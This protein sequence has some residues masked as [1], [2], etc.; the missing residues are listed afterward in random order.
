[1][2]DSENDASDEQKTECGAGQVKIITGI[3]DFKNRP[4]VRKVI[5]L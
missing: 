1:M 5:S 2:V 4:Q 3:L